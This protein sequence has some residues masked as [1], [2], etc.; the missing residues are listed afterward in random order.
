[1]VCGMGKSGLIGRKLAA[2]FAST[3][4]PSFFVHPAEA[5]HGDLGM[6]RAGDLVL[7]LSY[8]GETEEVVRLLPSLGAM[9]VATIA[10]VGRLESTL[11]QS[12][13]VAIDVSVEREACPHNL[14]PTS[15]TLT[16]L[17]IG[18][19]LA[20]ALMRERDFRPSDFAR[21]HP[22]G[23]LG[24]RLLA[25]VK[26]KMV[27]GTL[28][29]VTTE[30]TVGQSL[31]T[32]TRGRLGILLVMDAED[33]RRLR[34]VVTDGDLR[35]AMQRHDDLL[36]L[37]ITRIMTRTPITIDPEAS[38]GDAENLMRQHKV[39]ALVVLDEQGAP[40]GVLDLF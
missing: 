5:L 4:T 35:R 36:A 29:S 12:V 17:A 6:I 25:R 10:L 20:V 28:P 34:G 14:A 19:A 11:A 24:R 31:L 30:Q 37:P 2:T 40:V 27:T 26:D 22:G 18:D 13:D 3:G 23:S 9:Q 32:L 1:M 15:S 21:F 39:T 7:L 38:L 33:P 16:T 8:S